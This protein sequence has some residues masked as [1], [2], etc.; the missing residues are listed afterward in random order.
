MIW[1]LVPPQWIW[2]PSAPSMGF[3]D[4][5]P[6]SR[7]VVKDL[8]GES[9]PSRHIRRDQFTVI[10]EATLMRSSSGVCHSGRTGRPARRTPLFSRDPATP[11]PSQRVY[12]VWLFFAVVLLIGTALTR[13]SPHRL[14]P[15]RTRI[16]VPGA[17]LPRG[18]AHQLLRH[19]VLGTVTSTGLVTCQQ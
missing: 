16:P 1:L 7:A 8:R 17:A 3:A 15:R 9:F 11:I 14:L 18:A 12:R 4:L 13:C 6:A 2:Q 5:P 10:S 19:R